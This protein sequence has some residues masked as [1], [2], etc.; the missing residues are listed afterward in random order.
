MEDEDDDDDDDD[1]DEALNSGGLARATTTGI[2]IV[3][4][5]SK[6]PS[7]K[8]RWGRIIIMVPGQ[9][10]WCLDLF[11]SHLHTHTHEWIH[12][13]HVVILYNVISKSPCVVFVE[14]LKAVQYI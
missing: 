12:G 13:V 6:V 8:L 10:G 4:L 9:P 7:F 5:S 2:I 1:D 11:W 14:W 3:S